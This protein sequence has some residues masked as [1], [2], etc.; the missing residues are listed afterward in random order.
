M[1]AR[2]PFA[3]PPNWCGALLFLCSLLLVVLKTFLF[4]RLLYSEESPLV[5]FLIIVVI[6]VVV[7]VVV[8]VL[9]WID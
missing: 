7:V 4:V 3:F 2:R 1:F 9:F 8:G 6:F 5:Y